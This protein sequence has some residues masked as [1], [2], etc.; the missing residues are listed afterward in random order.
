[1]KDKFT[2]QDLSQNLIHTHI[3]LD[4]SFL[5]RLLVNASKSNK[6]HRAYKFLC[7]LGCPINK[8]KKASSTVYGWLKGYRTVPMSKLIKIVK[9]SDYSWIDIEKHLISIKA[10][11]RKGEISLRL[12]I[13]VD[14]KIGSIIG[15]VLGDGSI[16]KIF[17]SLFFSNS[18]SELLKEFRAYMKNIFGIEPRIWVQQKTK[19]FEEK[20]KWLVRVHNLDEVP[21]G[22]CV[23][24]FYPKICTDI[25]YSIFG[26]F[27]V[28]KSKKITKEIKDSNLEFKRGLIR[29][30]FDDEGSIRS[31]NHTMRFHQD[32]K[33]LLEDL[34]QIIQE[35]RINTNPI[36]HYYKRGKIRY[37]FNL[38]GY[39]NYYKFYHLIACTSS[40]KAE[41][42]E[43]LIESVGNSKVFKKKYALS[44]SDYSDLRTVFFNRTFRAERR[45]GHTSILTESNK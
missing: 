5:N 7:E 30:F 38:T 9:L 42:F 11:I 15:H 32:N 10:G 4:L 45:N 29:A 21:L 13:I 23:G 26:K 20:S 1:M 31:D 6:P 8:T 17:S 27:A 28:G 25:L 12:P 39:R 3:R 37:Y 22:Y 18:N 40:K 33:K 24:L 35:F 43:L 44:A 19:A 36:R 16:D 2:L 41:Q 14:H 34:K